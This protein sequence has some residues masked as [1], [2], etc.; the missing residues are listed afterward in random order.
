MYSLYIDTHYIELVLALFK[1]EKIVC[2][3]KLESNKHSENTINLL[4]EL[5]IENN[6]T[7]DNLKEIIVINGPGSF[8]GVRIGVVIAKIIGYTKNINIKALSYL[9]AVSLNYDK[10]VIVGLKDRNGIFIGEFDKEHN[11]VDD[12]YYLSNKEFESFD[13][14]II[15]DDVVDILKVINYMKDKE[16][17]NPH[18]LKPLYVKRIEVEKC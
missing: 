11:L 5:L 9:E 15:I 14:N 13:K 1:N 2:I 8:T 18:L 12:Y 3:K 17:I 16:V 7:V 10:D 6:I 4:N